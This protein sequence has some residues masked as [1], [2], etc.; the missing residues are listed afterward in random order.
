MP[1]PKITRA[2]YWTFAAVIVGLLLAV[3]GG[4]GL[5]WLRHQI[6]TTAQR[7]QKYEGEIAARERRLLHLEAR[8]AAETKPEVLKQRSRELGLKLKYPSRM[9]RLRSAGDEDFVEGQIGSGVRANRTVAMANGRKFE[10][11]E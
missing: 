3:G 6:A 4:L 11:I 7:V 8:I 5:I 1:V 2:F 9:I 10:R